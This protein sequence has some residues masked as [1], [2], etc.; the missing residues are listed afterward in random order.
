MAEKIAKQAPV[1]RMAFI[2]YGMQGRTAL[3]PNFI[4]HENVVIKAVCDCDKVRREAGAAFV[5]D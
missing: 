2:G 4:R 1:V 5:N 3:V